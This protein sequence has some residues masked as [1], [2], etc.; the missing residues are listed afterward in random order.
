M[1]L[2]RRCDLFRVVRDSESHLTPATSHGVAMSIA[3]TVILVIL[4]VGE[5]YGYLNGHTSCHITPSAF[6][7]ALDADK[8]RELETLHFSISLPYMPCHRIS[9]EA[10]SLSVRNQEAE[11]NTKV[12]LSHVP[13]GSYVSKSSDVYIP[14][15]ALLEVDQ[16]CLVIGT[17]PI[18]AMPSSLNIMLKNY[19]PSDMKK[20]R[21]DFRIHHFSAGNAYKDWG[22][23][24]VRR[25]T[26]E[27]LSGLTLSQNLPSPYFYQFFLQLIPTAVE[28]SDKDDRFGYQYTAFHSTLRNN[29][30]GRPP[31]L[32]FAYKRSPFS[33]KC[34]VQYDTRGHF[35][36]NLCAVVGGVYTVAEMVG[37]VLEWVARERR[38]REVSAH[39]RHK[40]ETH[41]SATG[42]VGPLAD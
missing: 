16:G 20:Y 9:T 12:V 15:E 18:A 4:F 32:Y 33:M 5:I 21:P 7:N 42:K 39:N 40:A 6:K 38:L 24:Q 26:L 41:T 30:Q 34:A 36:V 25:Q 1:R 8:Q 13:Y 37:A 35:V 22:V 28:R 27:P 23:P 3:T 2:L 31:G 14:G 10:V 11:R 17:S 29:G 19:K